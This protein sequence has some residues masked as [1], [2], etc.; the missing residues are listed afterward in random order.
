MGSSPAFEIR[1]ISPGSTSLTYCAFM[2]SNAQVSEATAQ[3]SLPSGA[4]NFPSASGRNHRG[5][6]T[7]YSSSAV[8][9]SSE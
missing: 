9:T 2:R 5:S 6:R 8:K 1:S 7:A 4:V 3:A